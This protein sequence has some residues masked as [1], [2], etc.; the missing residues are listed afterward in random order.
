MHLAD[1]ALYVAKDK[2]RDRVLVWTGR[3]TRELARISG[4]AKKES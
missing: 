3:T 4:G 1:K 2:G